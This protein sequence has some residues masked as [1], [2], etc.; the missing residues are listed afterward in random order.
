MI[1]QT[2]S[3]LIQYSQRSVKHRVDVFVR[4][5][6]IRIEKPQT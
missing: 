6:A 1:W 5:D 3:E 2:M 4:L